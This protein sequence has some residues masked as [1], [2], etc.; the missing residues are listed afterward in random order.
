MHKPHDG[1]EENV[2]LLRQ[3]Q[4]FPGHYHLW[5]WEPRQG[6]GLR[7]NCHHNRA[8]NFKHVFSRIARIQYVVCKPIM[9]YGLLSERESPAG[10]RNAPALNPKM[11]R[12]LSV[13]PVTSFVDEHTK[14][15]KSL[16]WFG[17]PERNTL[18]HCVLY[19]CESLCVRKKA[20]LVMLHASPFI[21]QGGHV[22]EC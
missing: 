18:L 17:P 4:G 2:H 3:N 20:P 8:F 5:R 16:E 11:R 10:W 21:V 22:Q 1:R 13:L 12:G 9:S 19:C 14:A 7:Q 15:H 6:Q